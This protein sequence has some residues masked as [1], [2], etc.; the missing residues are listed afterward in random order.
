MIDRA[1]RLPL[2]AKITVP[3]I[4]SSLCGISVFLS[5]WAHQLGFSATFPLHV[6]AGWL[7][8]M[9][10]LISEAIRLRLPRPKTAEM[11]LGLFLYWAFVSAMWSLDLGRTW[12][13]VY[14]YAYCLAI[15]VVVLRVAQDRKWWAFLG[16][17]IIA[18]GFL[19]SC[20][21]LRNATMGVDT[22]LLGDRAT[23]GEINPNF[24]AYSIAMSVPVALL[25]F[26]SLRRTILARAL[27]LLHLMAASAAIMF[28]GS[29]G[30]LGAVLLSLFYFLIVMFR[31]NFIWAV[32]A[33]ILIPIIGLQL[34]AQLPDAVQL[35]LA[36]A[37]AGGSIGLEK[38]TGREEVW[39]E[40]WRTIQHHFW[41]GIGIGAFASTNPT[42]IPAHNALLSI[43][44]ETGIVGVIL[45]FGAI[46]AIFWRVV[47]RGRAMNVRHCG[48]TLLLTWSIISM[49]GVWEYSGIIWIVFAWFMASTTAAPNWDFDHKLEMLGARTATRDG[50]KSL[51]R[52]SSAGG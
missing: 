52:A 39:P 10:L 48:V 47:F 30:A 17:M 22:E 27:L 44:A 9:L 37:F 32:L 34:Y 41:G 4:A 40:A 33:L 20:I 50:N 19:A 29:R 7:S 12:T 31:R 24:I 21:V 14:Y 13:L 38:L 11:F 28:S 6:I 8:L 3:A 49:T 2:V 42:Q 18:S 35:R 16:W 5:I 45:Y 15:F 51:P 25:V 43:A 36:F 23:I 1:S 46:G 26:A